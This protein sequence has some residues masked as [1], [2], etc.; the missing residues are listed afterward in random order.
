[1]KNMACQ[2]PDAISGW[3]HTDYQC[4]G[5]ENKMYRHVYAICMNGTQVYC[6]TEWGSSC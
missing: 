5:L 3:T 2:C 1:M 6:R 4:H